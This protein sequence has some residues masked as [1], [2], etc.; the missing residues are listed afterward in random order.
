MTVT[1]S[2][3]EGA[4]RNKP[5]KKTPKL[6]DGV[7]KRGNTWSYVIRVKD[8]D[9]GISKPKWVSGFATEE[10]AEAARDEGRVKAWRGE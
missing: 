6:R 5:G 4:H 3:E 7:M 1:A 9:T 8:P 10:E 2:A